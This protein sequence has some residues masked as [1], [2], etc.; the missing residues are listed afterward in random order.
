MTPRDSIASATP[1]A[2]TAAKA[3]DPPPPPPS[4]GPKKASNGD[5]AADL[6]K[7]AQNAVTT[8]ETCLLEISLAVKAK[9][10]VAM[11]SNLETARSNCEYAKTYLATN[12]APGFSDQNVELF[13]AADACKSA[14]GA[15]LAYIDTLAPSKLAD[16]RRHV[17]DG[18]TYFDRGF[19]DL[20][21][22]LSELGVAHVGT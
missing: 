4:S 16:F 21:A 22:R 9:N 20:N 10:D 19:H 3:S 13:A 5:D 15:G 14:T 1:A 17:R 6:H 8:A 18:N 11:A 2:T 12:T 7:R